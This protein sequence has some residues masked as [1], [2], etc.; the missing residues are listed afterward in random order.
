MI[1]ESD[2]IANSFGTFVR[3]T[4]NSLPV[5]EIGPIIDNYKKTVAQ[6]FYSK[7]IEEFTKI[8]GEILFASV[9]VDGE[10]V[11]Y[12]YDESMKASFFCN[13]PTNRIYMGLP[14]NEDLEKIMNLYGLEII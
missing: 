12:Y 1:I 4:A 8:R 5:L 10:Y 2:K 9:K 11:G 14:V 3:G 7:R 6:R 13:S